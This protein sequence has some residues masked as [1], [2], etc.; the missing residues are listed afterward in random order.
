MSVNRLVL[1]PP[2]ISIHFK[3]AQCSYSN[4]FWINKEI[5]NI[6]HQSGKAGMQLRILYLYRETHFIFGDSAKN[7]QKVPGFTFNV[8]LQML[9]FI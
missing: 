2:K 3:K 6:V 8:L 1:E 4:T 9:C 5:P 7:H